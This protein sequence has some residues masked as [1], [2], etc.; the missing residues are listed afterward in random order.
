M[1][2]PVLYLFQGY[3]SSTDAQKNAYDIALLISSSWSNDRPREPDGSSRN[4]KRTRSEVIEISSDEDGDPKTSSR[5]PS[6]QDRSRDLSSIPPPQAPP[7]LNQS[8]KTSPNPSSYP[9]DQG[10]K[11]SDPSKS[12]PFPNYWNSA[13][14]V[15]FND[16]YPDCPNALRVEDIIGPKDR[17]KMALV[18]SYVLELP[19]I[20]KLFNPRTRIMVIRH[21]TDLM[22]CEHVLVPSPNA[23]NCNGNAQNRLH[24]YQ[25]EKSISSNL[26]FYC[27]SKL[28]NGVPILMILR[29]FIIFYDNFVD[30]DPTANAVSFD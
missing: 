26:I 29:F 7:N 25:V 30:R 9:T 5:S 15:T 16:W 21:H 8:S 18:S 17:I 1:R 6:N 13:I 19:W 11:D 20:H 27:R 2:F 22:T 23:Q 28:S 3:I 24:A 14:K 4:L 10:P 12:E